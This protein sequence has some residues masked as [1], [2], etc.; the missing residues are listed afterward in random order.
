MWP[1]IWGVILASDDILSNI[2]FIFLFVIGAFAMRS[3]GCIINDI[4]DRKIDAQVE[5]TK[6]RPLASG[7]LKVKEA[8]I[9]LA[10]M[11]LVG[12]FVF[13]QLNSL[14]MSVA[15]LA[16]I[17]A[18]IYPFSKRFFPYPQVVL[19]MAFNLGAI[20][21]YA[22][23]AHQFSLPAVLLYI[24]GIFWTVGYDTI[25]GNQD[26]KDDAIIGV[27]STALSFGKYNKIIIALCY[28]FTF[29]FIAFASLIENEY[30]FSPVF[31]LF[32]LM[33]LM[34]Q[35]ITVNLEDSIECMAKFKSNAYITGFLFALGLYIPKLLIVL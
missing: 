25:Y 26:K 12:L 20:I 9:L 34:Y 16:F 4:A 24:G 7:D 5:R 30:P 29:L 27:K 18:I 13:V 32:A 31:L 28:I 6:N 33:H 35:I 21:G 17:L 23:I 22:V 15:V 11:L 14:A 19:G 3:A 8:F 10:I 2:Y 1:C